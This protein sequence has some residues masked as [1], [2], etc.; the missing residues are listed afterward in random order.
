MAR[1]GQIRDIYPKYDAVNI[2]IA[3]NWYHAPV[4]GPRALEFALLLV[5]FGV[6]FIFSRTLS[7]TKKKK[8]SILLITLVLQIIFH[9]LRLIWLNPQIPHLEPSF[10]QNL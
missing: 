9:F 4:F 2:Y 10:Q 5:Y 3:T 8:K 7:S 1:Y 6:L